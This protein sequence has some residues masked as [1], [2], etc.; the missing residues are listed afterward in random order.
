MQCSQIADILLSGFLVQ[1]TEMLHGRHV[2]FGGLLWD[3]QLLHKLQS[4][5]AF[6]RELVWTT[7]VALSKDK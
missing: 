3:I 1:V 5:L 6:V 7:V 2:A 4:P